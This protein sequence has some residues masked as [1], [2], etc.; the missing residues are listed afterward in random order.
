MIKVAS[1]IKSFLQGGMMEQL[2]R[3][4]CVEIADLI[5]Q[6]VYQKNGK[7]SYFLWKDKFCIFGIEDCLPEEIA[8]DKACSISC[9]TS[10]AFFY[11]GFEV[12]DKKVENNFFSG[13]T[14]EVYSGLIRAF[15]ECGS[16]IV[17]SVFGSDLIEFRV[18]IPSENFCPAIK[19]CLK[20]LNENFW[21]ENEVCI[22]VTDTAIFVA[23]NFSSGALFGESVLEEI[24]SYS[25][26]FDI[27]EKSCE[28]SFS[29]KKILFPKRQNHLENFIYST[30]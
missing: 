11:L 4:A 13:E 17:H 26:L 8:F 14:S 29:K 3:P 18:F 22:K 1:A 16:R 6:R 5:F 27:K 28:G 30:K 9:S 25:T 21:H 20:I 24:C 12:A 10:F 19:N 23:I 7:V 15:F 2:I